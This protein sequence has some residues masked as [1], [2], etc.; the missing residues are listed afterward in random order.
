MKSMKS[1]A[2]I[3]KKAKVCIFTCGFHNILCP[4]HRTY[5]EHKSSLTLGFLVMLSVTLAMSG[6][7]QPH[8]L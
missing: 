7:L 3:L 8:G 4:E 6:S 5:E 2:T 1:E